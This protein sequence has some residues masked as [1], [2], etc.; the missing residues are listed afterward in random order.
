MTFIPVLRTYSKFLQSRILPNSFW[1]YIKF[2]MGLTQ[3][4]WP[5]DKTCLVTHPRR[6]YVGVNSRI[7]SQGTYIAGM[8]GIY[9]GDNVIFGPNVGILSSNHDLYSRD[10]NIGSPIKIGNYCW[11]GM[12]SLVLAGVEL[13]PSTIVGGGSVVTKSFPEGYCVIAGNPAKI[14]KHLDKER[15]EKEYPHYEYEFNG[16]IPSRKFDKVKR[17]YLLCK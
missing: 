8:G 14:I 13:G 15:V 16:F 11:I 17:K 6:I 12:N 7:G 4:Y 2:R 5:K 3:T 10:K 9:I 1:Q